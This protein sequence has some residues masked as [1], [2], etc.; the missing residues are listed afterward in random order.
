MSATL[1][2]DYDTLDDLKAEGERGV[3]RKKYFSSSTPS[4]VTKLILRIFPLSVQIEKNC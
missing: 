2:L 4:R 1:T 3:L